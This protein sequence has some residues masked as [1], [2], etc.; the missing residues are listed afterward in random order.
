MKGSSKLMSC[1]GARTML[2]YGKGAWE[3]SLKYKSEM[4][5]KEPAAKE[6]Q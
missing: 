5:L 6:N 4:S 3:T 2:K 1:R